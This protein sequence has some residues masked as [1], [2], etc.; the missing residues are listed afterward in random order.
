M[1]KGK[2]KGWKIFLTGRGYYSFEEAK[3]TVKKLKI[4]ALY[5]FNEAYGGKKK[6][7]DMMPG[8]PDK[9]YKEFTTWENFL[10]IQEKIQYYQYDECVRVLK[11]CKISSSAKFFKVR[12]KGLLPERVPS[13]PERYYKETGD[14]KNW[15]EFLSNKVIKLWSFEKAKQWIKQN[16]VKSQTE[17][18]ALRKAGKMPRQMP[19]SPKLVYSQ[20]TREHFVN[21]GG[22]RRRKF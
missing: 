3:K 11:K 2:W 4:Q 22:L 8:H 12:S 17:Y 7:T 20:P 6:F 1:K 18:Q 9:F 5:Q 15:M 14:W 13:H 16:N 10:G 19:T 21:R